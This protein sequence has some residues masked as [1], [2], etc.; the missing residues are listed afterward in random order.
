MQHIRLGKT[1]SQSNLS[2]KYVYKS[3]DKDSN[4]LSWD[5]D[6]KDCNTTKALNLTKSLNDL[7]TLDFYSQLRI[8]H[9]GKLSKEIDESL[10]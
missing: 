10:L 4:F 5:S 7:Y 8:L 6:F 9:K 2:L 1:D 3:H